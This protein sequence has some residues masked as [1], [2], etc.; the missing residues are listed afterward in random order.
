MACVICAVP[1]GSFRRRKQPE[2]PQSA[3]RPAEAGSDSGPE[4]AG[5]GRRSHTHRNRKSWC[6][7]DS[8]TRRQPACRTRRGIRRTNT[9]RRSPNSLRQRPAPAAPAP[10]TVPSAAVPPAAAPGA[11]IPVSAIPVAGAIPREVAAAGRKSTIGTAAGETTRHSTAAHAT[12][13]TTA[14]APASTAT[15]TAGF[16]ATGQHHCR[17]AYGNRGE[18][19]LFPP[20]QHLSL[21]FLQKAGEI[22]HVRLRGAKS[23]RSRPTSPHL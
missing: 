21:P 19:Q 6:N 23:T 8:R 5:S 14:S 15:P 17:A 16:D 18:H 13:T 7:R 10:S 20:M 22:L 11:A 12:S 1:L 4:P 9:V 3:D 2:P